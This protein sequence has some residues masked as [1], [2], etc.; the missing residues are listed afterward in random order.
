M[1]VRR[2]GEKGIDVGGCCEGDKRVKEVGKNDKGRWV[3]AG[4]GEEGRRRR[5]LGL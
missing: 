4:F 1:N 5:R 2:Q 3:C